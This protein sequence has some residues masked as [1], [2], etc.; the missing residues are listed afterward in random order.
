MNPGLTNKQS[1]E[2]PQLTINTTTSTLENIF[3]QIIASKL[4]RY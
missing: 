3:I 2:N 1:Q 4:R